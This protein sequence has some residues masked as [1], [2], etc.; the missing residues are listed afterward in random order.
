MLFIQVSDN[1]KEEAVLKSGMCSQVF[2]SS[3]QQDRGGE[4]MTWVKMS[5]IMLATFAFLKAV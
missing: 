1:S 5:L 2:V 3:A 4:R